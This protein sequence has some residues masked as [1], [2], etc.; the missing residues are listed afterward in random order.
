[1]KAQVSSEL[2]SQCRFLGQSLEL[3]FLLL[4]DGNQDSEWTD[5][6][7]LTEVA[8]GPF[9]K[10]SW[11]DLRLSGLD[12]SSPCSLL[13]GVNGGVAL[14]WPVGSESLLPQGLLSALC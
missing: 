7:V 1:M 9:V 3:V 2:F 4:W 8:L 10:L 14:V 13:G 11:A 5:S 12:A 6:V